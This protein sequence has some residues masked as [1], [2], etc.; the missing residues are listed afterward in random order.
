MGT[1]PGTTV[2]ACFG[3][4][5]IYDGYGGFLGLERQRVSNLHGQIRVQYPQTRWLGGGEG[6]VWGFLEVEGTI[7]FTSHNLEGFGRQNSV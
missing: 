4:T 3:R 7:V 1:E 2:D 5:G 6:V